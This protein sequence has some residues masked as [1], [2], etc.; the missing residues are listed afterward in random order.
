[1]PHYMFQ[2]SLTNELLSLGKV[3]SISKGKFVICSSLHE[4]VAKGE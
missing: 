2:V 3:D 1:M 4:L